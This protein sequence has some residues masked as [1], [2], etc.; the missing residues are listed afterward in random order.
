MTDA[1][2]T[3]EAIFSGASRRRENTSTK[4][5]GGR[6]RRD[7]RSGDQMCGMKKNFPT[8]IE[9]EYVVSLSDIV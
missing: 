2:L 4:E 6:R 5:K 1:L 8:D 7:D 3:Q 9:N